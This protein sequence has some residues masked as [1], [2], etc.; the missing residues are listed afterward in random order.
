MISG[1]SN[2]PTLTRVGNCLQTTEVQQLIGSLMTL[3]AV[4]ASGLAGPL[5]AK[6]GRRHC[7]W[8]ASVL[9]CVSNVVMMATTSV[10]AL[11]FARLLLGLANGVFMSFS[12]LYL[13]ECSPARFRGLAL[14]AFQFWTSAGTLIGTIVDNYTAKIEGK[15]SYLIPLGLIYIVPVI[16]SVLLFTIPESPRWLLE[17]GKTEKAKKALYWLRPDPGSVEGEIVS[18]QAAID[19]AKVRLSVLREHILFNPEQMLICNH[20]VQENQGRHLFF[21]IFKNPVDRRRAVLAVA[22]VNTQAA[23][24]AM[25]M[26]AYGT[27]FFQM[28]GV[29]Q[30][31]T[32]SIVLVVVGVIAVIINTLVITR[33]GYRRIFLMTGLIICG[34]VQLI[35]AAV[36]DARPTAP[37]TLKLLV[38]LSV[39]YILAYNGLISS[40]AWVSGGELPSQRLRSYTFGLAASTGFFGA[41]LATFTAPYFINPEALNWGPKY[42]YIW[43]PSCAITAL[44]VFFFLPEVKG[45]TL[46]EIDEMFM[47]HVPAR[48]FRKYECTG[49]AALESKMRNTSADSDAEQ[50]SKKM[51]GDVET[52]EMVFGGPEKRVADA[53]ETAINTR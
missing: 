38:A 18:I 34:S 33:Y 1:G 31:F 39:I 13:Q 32:M 36:Y 27:Y 11:Y 44:W 53:V 8:L 2:E 12:Q 46:E 35:L 28:A 3:G 7:I 19:E 4:V 10:G 25:Y 47:A 40:Y 17:K 50:G 23:S 43:A 42:G 37:S 52:I 29:G 30:P 5:A 51:H 49:S 16:M 26:I 14:S 21:E 6:L 41:W 9:C 22:A 24:G 20:I 45:R 15:A 48:K